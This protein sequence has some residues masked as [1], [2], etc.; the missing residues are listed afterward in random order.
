MEV[1]KFASKYIL[2]YKW[3]FSIYIFLSLLAGGISL[4]VP[5]I[6]GNFIDNLSGEKDV[7]MMIHHCIIF[8]LINLVSIVVGFI[9]NRLYIKIQVN[10]A[11]NLNKDIISHL[12]NV[13]I[14]N[15]SNTDSSYLTQRINN[16]SNS[17]II[18]C[19]ETIIQSIINLFIIVYSLL[20]L[21][22]INIMIT[23]ILIFL[24]LLY[25]FAY[26][27]FEKPLYE[28]SYEFTESKS[29][30]FSKLNEQISFI[31]FIK[32]HS[33]KEF[34]SSR[35]NNNFR[36]F[37]EKAFSYQNLVYIFSS[38]DNIIH[39]LAQIVI[40]FFAGFEIIKGNLTIGM[41]TIIISYFTKILSSTRYFFNI[42]KSYQDNLVS[43][44]RII[45]FFNMDNQSNGKI[46]LK[47]V[48]K[49]EVRGL[50]FGYSGKKILN[51]MNL[52]FEKGKIYTIIG[53]NGSGK[54]TLVNLIMGVYIDSF[55][56]EILFN[57]I[58]I[59]DID[60]EYARKHIISIT[61]QEPYLISDTLDAN[62]GIFNKN[63][64]SDSQIFIELLSLDKYISSLECGIKTVISEKCENISGGEKQ[65]ISLIRQFSKNTDVM[66][67]DEPTSALDKETKNIFYNYINEIKKD[68]IIILISHDNNLNYVDEVI[69]L[70]SQILAI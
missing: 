68:K 12:H 67:F 58:N 29:E 20:I 25:L 1:F 11:F 22:K 69:D 18:F 24:T 65:K 35:L 43:Y 34:F 70:N 57:D 32:V 37:F 8:L 45:D 56:G 15:F 62:I 53:H 48:D 4:Y 50:D 64:I 61:E 9:N 66:I 46:K 10:S 51:D 23:L 17:I 60:M 33:L 16:D 31:K 40:Y 21:S 30:F 55:D 47:Q 19:I 49:I 54:S 36:S 3:K 59:Y 28:K 26:K 6:T 38:C 39:T 63:N 52:S 42:G 27:L 5:M 7:N 41:F 44:N 14:M 13:S 2:E